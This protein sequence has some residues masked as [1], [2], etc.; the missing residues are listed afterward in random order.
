MVGGKGIAIFLKSYI[1]QSPLS[2]YVKIIITSAIVL[3]SVRSVRC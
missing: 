3:Y 2:V 1:G